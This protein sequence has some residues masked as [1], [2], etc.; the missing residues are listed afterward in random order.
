[1]NLI[2]PFLTIN[3]PKRNSWHYTKRRTFCQTICRHK[4]VKSR[5]CH[6]NSPESKEK[7]HFTNQPDYEKKDLFNIVLLSNHSAF[8]NINFDFVYCEI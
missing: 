2:G 3:L 8:F 7:S 4:Y 5:P 6:S 1:M